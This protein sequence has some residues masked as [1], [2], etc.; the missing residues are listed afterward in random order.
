[1]KHY[2][3]VVFSL[4]GMLAAVQALSA[5]SAGTQPLSLASA[6]EAITQAST[7][8]TQRYAAADLAQAKDK[9]ARAREAAEEGENGEARRLAEQA[10]VDARYAEVKAEAQHTQALAESGTN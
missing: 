5:C 6:E 4:L 10:T 3:R 9:L 2:Y 8:T 7:A 1:M